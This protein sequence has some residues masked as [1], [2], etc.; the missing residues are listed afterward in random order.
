MMVLLLLVAKLRAVAVGGRKRSKRTCPFALSLEH[1]SA[2]SW[3]RPRLSK[4]VIPISLG[5]PGS[6]ACE[7][8][9]GVVA[10]VG[11]VGACRPALGMKKAKGLTT[12]YD[13]VLQMFSAV[14]LRL[15][16]CCVDPTIYAQD[17]PRSMRVRIFC[18][19]W[20]TDSDR[21]LEVEPRHR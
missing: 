6:S 11:L 15:H 3:S 21:P 4:A 12:L 13:S 10:S 16:V 9:A 18:I 5:S 1:S 20:D 7:T 8:C 17:G 19:C 2:A 14:V